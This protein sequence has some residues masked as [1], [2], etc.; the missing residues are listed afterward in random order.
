MAIAQKGVAGQ[1]LSVVDGFL[2]QNITFND[3]PATGGNGNANGVLDL[4][5]LG[6]QVARS[7]TSRR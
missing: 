2:V 3:N 5:D 7:T 1:T 4:A 6:S